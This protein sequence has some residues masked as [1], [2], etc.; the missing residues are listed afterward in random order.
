[1]VANGARCRT[2]RLSCD[3]STDQGVWLHYQ[4][5]PENGLSVL[6]FA[7]LLATLLPI[8]E[9]GFQKLVTAHKGKVVLYS[10]WATWCK[11][12]RAEMPRL[13]KLQAKLQARGLELV[14]M[15]AEE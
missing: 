9:S 2:V 7:L 1:H 6:P 13:I 10:F 5:R 3:Y 12:C 15:S 11:P 8:D 4:A 14:T